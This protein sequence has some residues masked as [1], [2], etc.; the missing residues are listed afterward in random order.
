MR[1]AAARFMDGPSLTSRATAVT[2]RPCARFSWPGQRTH[3]NQAGRPGNKWKK[4]KTTKPPNHHHRRRIDATTTTTTASAVVREEL[5]IQGDR[6]TNSLV[7]TLG[8]RVIPGTPLTLFRYIIFVFFFFLSLLLFS[9]AKRVTF[10]FQ[11]YTHV[12]YF[13]YEVRAAPV[14]PLKIIK[15]QR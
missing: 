8:R 4:K 12:L 14:S 3:D 15:K 10:D 2:C 11:L 7:D 1:A 6:P 5:R 13:I 9:G